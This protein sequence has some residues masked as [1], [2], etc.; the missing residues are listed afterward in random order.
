MERQSPSTDQTAQ[1]PSAIRILPTSAG[2]QA[3]HC[4][5]SALQEI[6]RVEDSHRIG[7]SMQS[8]LQFERA[9]IVRPLRTVRSGAWFRHAGGNLQPLR[10]HWWPLLH[11]NGRPAPMPV[12]SALCG[13]MGSPSGDK[14][15]EYLGAPQGSANDRLSGS[16]V[17]QSAVRV[18]SG[19]EPRSAP[20]ETPP[21]WQ[22]RWHRRR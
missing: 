20:E 10:R 9:C 5:H 15:A 3:V 7:H 17:T 1:W 6:P 2:R 12:R 21:H 14:G 19:C 18:L 16:W 4:G 11:D 8:G 13:T 22:E